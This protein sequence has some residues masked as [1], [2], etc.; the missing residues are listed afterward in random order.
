MLAWQNTY[1]GVVDALRLTAERAP[2]E[3]IPGWSDRPRIAPEFLRLWNSFCA[4]LRWAGE[5]N[6]LTAG[7]WVR[8]QF[9]ADSPRDQAILVDVFLS[10][11][12][13][14]RLAQPMTEEG[15]PDG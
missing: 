8:T 3:F 2:H 11:A 14:H 9:W 6:S 7:D 1:G 13:A 4:Y 12:D 5:H 10:L 15:D